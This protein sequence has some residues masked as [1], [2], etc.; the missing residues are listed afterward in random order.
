[1][2]ISLTVGLASPG[3]DVGDGSPL[4]KGHREIRPTSPGPCGNN[5]PI[6]GQL[7]C[8]IILLPPQKG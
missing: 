6:A 5:L 7:A 3:A 8:I 2:Y 1:M 4:W